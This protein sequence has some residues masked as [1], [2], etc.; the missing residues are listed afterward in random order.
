[1]RVAPLVCAVAVGAAVLAAGPVASIHATAPV[2]P[3]LV[4]I[5]SVDGLSWPNLVKYKPWYS[6]GLKQ[7]LD[8]G[9]AFTQTRFEHINTE[10]SPGHASLSTGAP[11]RV[12][13]IVGNRWLMRDPDRAIRSVYSTRMFVLPS[14]PGGPPAEPLPARMS[15]T[16]PGNLR[17]DTLGDRLV[18]AHPTSRVVSVSAKDRTA[19]LLA[20]RNPRHLAYWFDRDTGQ[21]VTSAYYDT[22]GPAGIAGRD[23]VARFN[24]EQAGPALPARLGL[25]WR[26]LA[27][28]PAGPS[29]GEPAA[30]SPASLLLDLQFPVNGLGFPHNLAFGTRGYYASIYSSPFADELV[31]DLSLAFMTDKRVALGSR[32]TPDILFVGLS[33]QD[34]VSHAYGPESSENLDVLRRIDVLVARLLDTLL[35]QG[36][37]R[38]DVVV[39]LS[40]DHG[41]ADIPEARR[42]R[43]PSFGGGRLVEGEHVRPGF[44]ERLNRLLSESMCLPASSRPIFG[45]EGWSMIYNHPLLP[46]RTETGPCGPGNQPVGPADIDRA[47][48]GVIGRFFREEVEA[49]LL[50]S[51]R[52]TWPATDKAVSFVLNDFDAE[53]SGDAFVIPRYGVLMH[54]DPIRGTG[55][56]THHEYDT[57]VPLVF[58]GGNWRPGVSS[59]PATPYDLAPTLAA[60][61]GITLP[62]ATGR[63]LAVTKRAQ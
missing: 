55:H 16:G 34:T 51:Q 42:Q 28:L 61:L 35:T 45:G 60:T 57:H 48:P 31:M 50:V 62:D 12:T 1:V 19:V 27:Q 23:L 14:V 49:V 39:A 10:T 4:V 59:A 37:T 40:A 63:N 33:A 25:E 30:P 18:A 53:R 11:P 7:L 52:P 5:I 6:A 17:V 9:Y 26:P 43:D 29:V 22:S 54:D 41:F 3:R 20:G 24:R 15:L 8:D 58:W 13:G 38:D 32:A 56:G 36:F 44:Y 2:T 46:M 47:L 21:F